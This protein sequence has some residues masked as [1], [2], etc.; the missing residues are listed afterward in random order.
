MSV[1][2]A[3]TKTREFRIEKINDDD[4][5]S[6]LVSIRQANGYP[7]RISNQY[8]CSRVSEY[9][10]NHEHLKALVSNNEDI[11]EYCNKIEK[12]EL[13]G[14]E[15]QLQTLSMICRLAIYIVSASKTIDGDIQID[16]KIY[17]ESVKS[18]E[19]CVYIFYNAEH[20]HY[21]P[22]YVINM[23]NLQEKTKIFKRNDETITELL[24][25]FL[26][27]EFNCK[28]TIGIYINILI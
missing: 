15:V 10:R 16:K 17:G 9:I 19:D 22:L 21:D 20:K 25:I 6:L 12:G 28:K 14:D 11:N 23:E 3:F 2:A 13:Y 24:N 1:K 4:A 7:D 27:K 8:L 26:K 5:L 18:F